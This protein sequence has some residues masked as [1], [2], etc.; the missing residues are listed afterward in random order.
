MG[1]T[2]S[3]ETIQQNQ[4]ADENDERNPEMKV[5]QDGSKEIRAIDRF[6]GHSSAGVTSYGSSRQESTQ[7][8]VCLGAPND[9]DASGLGR[10]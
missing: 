5:G 9:S 7:S 6:T 10:T 3:T 1:K 8:S 2:Y 4:T